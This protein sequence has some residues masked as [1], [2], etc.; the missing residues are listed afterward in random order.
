MLLVMVVWGT[1]VK[2]ACYLHDC[3]VHVMLL[4]VVVWG[5]GI[6]KACCQMCPM[7]CRLW[8]ELA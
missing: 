4:M 6:E 3:P 5:T 2:K 8:W 1:G 7:L